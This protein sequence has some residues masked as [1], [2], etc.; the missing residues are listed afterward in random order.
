MSED[1]KRPKRQTYETWKEASHHI[2][3]QLVS[4]SAQQLKFAKNKDS[5]SE[6]PYI[7]AAAVL[8]E[9]HAE[10][11]NLPS[12]S[13]S[14]HHLFSLEDIWGEV[15]RRKTLPTPINTTAQVSAWIEYAYLTKRKRAL[16]KLKI[17]R[18][19]LVKHIW[20]DECFEV[21]SIS[22]SGCVYFVGGKGQR[23]WPDLLEVVE[24]AGKLSTASNLRRKVQ[25]QASERTRRFEFSVARAAEIDEFKVAKDLDMT[26]AIGAANAALDKATEEHPLQL[27]FA[28]FPILLTSRLRG[29]HGRYLWD[30]PR[31]AEKYIPDFII[32]EVDSAGIHYTLVELESPTAPIYLKNGNFAKGVR[33]G[34]NQ[35]Q[36]WRFWLQSN[37]SYARRSRRDGGLGLVDID[38]NPPGLLIVGRQHHLTSLAEARRYEASRQNDIEI[39]T[40]DGILDDAR[41]SKGSSF[42]F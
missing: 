12:Q 13:P 19:D 11:L 30:R 34:M 31:L 24:R 42:T 37:I 7:V 23:C 3:A 40:Y 8:Q 36:D 1:T 32:A 14:Q 41:A 38:P 35:I 2:E 25:N 22:T 26:S 10:V 17:R 4:V 27:V 16:G 6:L 21:A 5:L 29:G 28:Q 15:F 18:G 39:R 9:Q 33:D 20:N